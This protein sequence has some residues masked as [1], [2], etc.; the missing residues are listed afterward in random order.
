[1]SE[2][3]FINAIGLS[4][5]FVSYLSNQRNRVGF[6]GSSLC[7]TESVFAIPRMTNT[8]AA[9][10]PANVGSAVYRTWLCYFNNA[11]EFLSSF[12]AFHIA[13]LNNTPPTNKHL[14]TDKVL[15]LKKKNREVSLSRLNH[16][17]IR[18]GRINAFHKI[19]VLIFF[20]RRTVPDARRAA[21]QHSD[22]ED[23]EGG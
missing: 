11:V 14:H 1:M 6:C 2:R 9:N 8:F 10:L 17:S 3:Q 4:L 16:T 7:H 23:S 18:L 12:L 19:G 22:T 15:H 5:A 13:R 21:S 20:R